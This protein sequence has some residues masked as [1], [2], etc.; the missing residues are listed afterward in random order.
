MVLHQANSIHIIKGKYFISMLIQGTLYDVT[1]NSTKK[2]LFCIIFLNINTLRLRQNSHHFADSIFKCIF[3][4]Q[5]FLIPTEMSLNLVP[6]GPINNIPALFQIMAWQWPGHKHL[7]EPMMVSLLTHICVTR[8][9]WVKEQGHCLQNL[10]LVSYVIQC[11]SYPFAWNWPTTRFVIQCKS[12]SFAWN[13][14]TTRNVIQCKSYP[15]AWNWPTTRNVIQ[16]KSYPFAWNW[17]ITRNCGYW[18]RG[19]YGTRTAVATVLIMHPYTSSCFGQ[20][21]D[22]TITY[23]ITWGQIGSHD[24]TLYHMV[25]Y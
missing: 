18:W 3:L 19:V 22:W 6:K 9:Q 17:P 8:P 16:C 5:N 1:G 25:S 15:F 24:A 23:F 10:M 4:N 12:Y 11:K 7:S 13:W 14:P 21:L 2:K 20:I